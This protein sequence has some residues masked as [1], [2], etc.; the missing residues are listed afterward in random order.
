VTFAMPPLVFNAAAAN[1]IL[2]S[3]FNPR[4]ENGVAVPCSLVVRVKF[5]SRAGTGNEN[6]PELKT[7]AEN[8]RPKAIAGDPSSQLAYGMLLE[9]IAARN[10][11]AE[12]PASWYLKA[13]QAGIPTAQYLIGAPMLRATEPD[14]AEKVKKG[15]FWVTKA[16]D[17]GQV[18]AQ[19]ALANYLLSQAGD[20]DNRARAYELLENAA[21]SE[22]REGK[23]RLAALLA[24]DAD[25]TRRDPKRAL[26]L[27]EQVMID[28]ELD[29]IAYELRAAANAALGDFEAAKKDQG[30]AIRMAAKLDWDLAPLKARLAKY[31][32]GAAWTGDLL[33]P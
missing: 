18:D 16:A 12:R 6:F 31:E 1:V 9:A 8:A 4:T 28:K 13:A 3:A 26:T 32:S 15:L 29:P 10:P 30:R 25:D 33:A 24:S 23:Y 11:A 2:N 20:P 7:L 27:L 19:L 17:G 5:V 21:M 22:S 14:S